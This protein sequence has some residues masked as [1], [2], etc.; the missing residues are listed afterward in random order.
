MLSLFVLSLLFVAISPR[1]SLASAS[2]SDAKSL[3]EELAELEGLSE[4]ES[5]HMDIDD[6]GADTLLELFT[7]RI[8]GPGYVRP[9]ADPV[10][11][12]DDIQSFNAAEFL[13]AD[14]DA[15]PLSIQSQ[16]AIVNSICYNIIFNGSAYTLLLP[17]SYLNQI[18]VDEQGYLW[19]MGTSTI[20]GRAFN[21]SFNPTADTGYLLYLNPCLGNNFSANHHYGSPN[22]LRRY[23]WSSGSLRSSDTYGVVL[24]ENPESF[25]FFQGD[26]LTYVIIFI[27][28]GMLIC[29]W[30]KSRL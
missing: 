12:P 15:A 13:D 3:I 26:T 30:R 22:Y 21:D 9:E 2:K 14:A 27:L 20:Q 1:S 23:Y 8:S 16:D 4:D 28:G 18:Y 25:S 11:T 6:F 5:K 10:E 19:N 24:V 17:S 29:L 7:S